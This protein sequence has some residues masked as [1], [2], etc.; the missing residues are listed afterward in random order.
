MPNARIDAEG[1]KQNPTALHP[2]D[3]RFRALDA[4]L[5][6]A[7]P[8]ASFRVE[9]ASSDASFRRYFRV[10]LS[11]PE[12]SSPTLIAMD[13]PPEREDSRPF[14]HVAG[15]LRAAGLNAPEIVR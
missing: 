1:Y 5:R 10:F 14:V 7:L 15:L 4:W 13:A 2:M 3:D 12:A 9:R 6:D 8:G 11:G